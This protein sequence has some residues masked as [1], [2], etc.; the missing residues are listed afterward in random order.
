MISGVVSCCSVS[1]CP[2][3]PMLFRRALV[4]VVAP[5]SAS[6]FRHAEPSHPCFCC[7]G[8]SVSLLPF[9]QILVMYAI[10]AAVV[11]TPSPHAVSRCAVP[12]A[13]ALPSC[14]Y[15]PRSPISLPSR[16]PA[17]AASAIVVFP[18]HSFPLPFSSLQP[19]RRLSSLYARS[20]PFPP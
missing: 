18:R 12:T 20:H 7:L 17:L 2:R 5:W 10:N 13:H 16:A 1:N 14:A 6:V 8:D 15:L 9:L 19:R 3:R 11:S 4:I